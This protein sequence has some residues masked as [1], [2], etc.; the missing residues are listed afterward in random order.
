M[1][2]F[3]KIE[4]EIADLMECYGD[5]RSSQKCGTWTEI[6]GREHTLLEAATSLRLLL[7]V[8]RAAETQIEMLD[9]DD[10]RFN[11]SIVLLKARAALKEHCDD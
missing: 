6:D 10:L 5:I 8:A 4:R 11:L 7:D 1:T 3:D 2:N 9:S